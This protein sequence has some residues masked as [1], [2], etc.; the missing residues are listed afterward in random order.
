MGCRPRA[1]PLLAARSLLLF[2]LFHPVIA[3]NPTVAQVH[4]APRDRAA[5]PLPPGSRRIEGDL[6]LSGQSFRETVRFF[7]RRL[8]RQRVAHEQRPIYRYRGV[9]VA[10][11]LSREATTWAAIHVFQQRDRTHI[12]IVRPPP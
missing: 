2:A 6:H 3:V 4:A 1:L 9:L 11:F 7:Q 10:R 8:A 5:L 12:F